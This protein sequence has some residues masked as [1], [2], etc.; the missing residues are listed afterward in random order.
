MI[1]YVCICTFKSWKYTKRKN[2]EDEQHFLVRQTF[3][4][5]KFLNNIYPLLNLSTKWIHDSIKAKLS[6]LYIFTKL[7]Q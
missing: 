1:L 2:E 6:V 7:P 4:S 3:T 5:L